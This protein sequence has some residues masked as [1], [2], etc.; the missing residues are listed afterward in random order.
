MLCDNFG[1]LYDI[2]QLFKKYTL[3]NIE[4]VQQLIKL[5]VFQDEN[6]YKSLKIVVV[7]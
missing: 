3:A 7:H 5:W 1:F 6:S 4:S 2:L